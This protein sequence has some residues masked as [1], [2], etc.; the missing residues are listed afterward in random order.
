MSWLVLGLLACGDDPGHEQDVRASWEERVSWVHPDRA[1]RVRLATL[2]GEVTALPDGRQRLGPRVG[3]RIVRWHVAPGDAVEAGDLLAE[4]V[5]ADLSEVA[6]RSAKL[7]AQVRLLE[8]VAQDQER[9]ADAGIVSRAGAARARAE[10]EAARAEWAAS[11]GRLRGLDGVAGSDGTWAFRAPT[12]G[13]IA[14]LTCS[15][16]TVEAGQPCVE[17]VDPQASQLVVWVPERFGAQ[18]DSSLEASLTGA[19]GR[20]WAFVESGRAPALDAERR[21]LEV[22]FHPLGAPPMVG[23]AGRTELVR[24]ASVDDRIVPAQALTRI[25]NTPVVFVRDGD[26]FAAREVEVIGVGATP[27]ERV[28][29]NV[30]VDDEV[31]VRGV[32][33]LKSLTLLEGE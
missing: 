28:V 14:A 29:R 6:G 31:A 20:T 19:D 24:P 10:L 32:F 2:P 7:A 21:A 23:I 3:G 15:L 5:S 4:L 9:A 33:L 27:E 30:S 13:E 18:L 25:D 1:E 11:R 26:G 16:D 8:Q 12:G 17:L 22:R